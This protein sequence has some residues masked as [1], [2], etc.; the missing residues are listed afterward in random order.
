L[1]D[2]IVD[3]INHWSV[4]L[5]F[6]VIKFLTWLAISPN[7]YY[8]WKRRYNNPNKHNSMIP[9]SNWLLSWEHEA[10][11]EYA[12]LHPLEGYRRL[13]YMMLDADVVTVGP[14]SVYRVLLNADLLN[15]KNVKPSK[16]GTG[17]VQ[18]TRPH[19]HWHSDISYINIA[20]TFYFLIS[21]LDGYSRYLIH[22][23]LR[24]TMKEEDLEITLQRAHEKFPEAKPRIISD[25]GPQYIA[26]D[27]KLFIRQME[28]T[29]VNTSRNYP[30]SN[31]KQERFHLILKKESIRQAYLND[32]ESA[33]NK[34]QEYI[35]YY[36]EIR[37]HSAI[38]YIAPLDKLLGNEENIFKSR[39]LKLTLATE[40][41][42]QVCNGK[43]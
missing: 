2:E 12:K 17:F 26:N 7:R 28:M 41:R 5:E 32:L 18:P 27:F 43:N 16:K 10:I 38:G 20:C 22:W 39:K 21:I 36:N 6:S 34:L 14:S 25:N 40:K 42:C 23:E 24:E 30:Q 4:K 15:E 11:K 9:K 33:K 31:G 29:H 19:Q 8:D 13:T 37:L 1:R 3:F 35:K